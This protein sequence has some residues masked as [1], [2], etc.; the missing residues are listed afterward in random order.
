MLE[1]FF[2]ILQRLLIV[3]LMKFSYLNYICL[4]FEEYLKIGSGPI[5]LTDNRKLK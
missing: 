1:E 3:W 2:V 4:E 5:L